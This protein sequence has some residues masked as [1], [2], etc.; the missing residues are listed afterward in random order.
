M[1]PAYIYMYSN[2]SLVPRLPAEKL[3]SMGTRPRLGKRVRLGTRLMQ[4]YYESGSEMVSSPSQTVLARK[5]D[6][7]TASP[8]ASTVRP[9][10]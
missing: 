1:H 5:M 2:T 10:R 6:G 8:T 3:G 9:V 4:I 7:V